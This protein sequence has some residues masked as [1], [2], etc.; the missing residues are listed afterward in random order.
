MLYQLIAAALSVYAVQSAHKD[1]AQQIKRMKTYETAHLQPVFIDTNTISLE[2]DAFGQHYEV[3]LMRQTHAT[4]SNVV[5]TNVHADVHGVISSVE[6]S[7]CDFY[8]PFYSTNCLTGMNDLFFFVHDF[9][10]VITME[11]Y[12]MTKKYQWY[13]PHSVK[14][15]EFAPELVHSIK[16]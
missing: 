6:E 9:H 7:V 4:P 12:S 11:E 14:V 10:S 15:V 1:R 3:E 5:H 16:F 13:Q 8:F 2:F